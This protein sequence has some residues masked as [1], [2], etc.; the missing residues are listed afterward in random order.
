MNE[1]Q[2][3]LFPTS[4]PPPAAPPAA[5]E[6]VIDLSAFPL[7]ESPAAPIG[8]QIALLDVEEYW[9]SQWKGMPEFCQDDLTPERSILIHFESDADVQAFAAAIQQSIGPNLKS[10]WYPEAE[11]TRYADKRYVT[12]EVLP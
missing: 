12:D 9:R 4:D 2:P 3:D 6:P 5:S 7:P 8:D 1:I 10:V 11:I